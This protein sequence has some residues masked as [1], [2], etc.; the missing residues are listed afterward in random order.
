MWPRDRSNLTQPAFDFFAACEVYDVELL[1]SLPSAGVLDR[2]LDRSFGDAS[3][4][5]AA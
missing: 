4:L 3:H 2:Q 1:T 5:P